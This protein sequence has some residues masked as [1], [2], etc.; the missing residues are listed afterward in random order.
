MSERLKHYKKYQ[1]QE[2]AGL[3]H[4]EFSEDS[5]A[6]WEDHENIHQK[7]S[8][9]DKAEIV[10]TEHEPLRMYLR[11]MGTIPLL[12]KENEIEIA[13]RIENSRKS[14]EKILFSFPYTINKVLSFKEKVIKD[15]T[16][17]SEIIMI[18]DDGNSSRIIKRRKKNLLQ[19]LDQ[20][21]KLYRKFKSSKLINC[22]EKSKA[23]LE[24][25]IEMISTLHLKESFISS[26]TDELKVIYLKIGEL[27]K[28]M[29]AISV[30]LRAKRHG[31]GTK[32]RL[33]S[34]SKK[35]ASKSGN[36][37]AAL[38]K[39]QTECRKEL[40]SY[41]SL[42][43]IRSSEM[44]EKMR[45]LAEAAEEISSAKK[46]M[47]ESNLRLVV[48]IAKR[49][50]GKGLDFD[51]LIQEGNIGL[52]RAIDK[53]EY[54]RGYKISTYATWWIRQ[55]I[56]R[57]LADQSRIIRMPV[58]MVD[59]QHQILRATREFLQEN[60]CEASPEDIAERIKIPTKKIK[61]ILKASKEPVSLETPI[62]DEEESHLDDFIEDKTSPSP[63]DNLIKQDLREQVENVLCRLNPK[64]SRIIR[65]RYGIDEDT[66][67]TL[68]ELGSDFNVSKER[69][70]QIE[71]KTI[72]K[73]R[74]SSICNELRLFAEKW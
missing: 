51:D 57:A 7:S 6:S 15:E 74:N 18:Q 54:Q 48:S 61:L 53:F 64:E 40:R 34:I 43:G 8:E 1:E 25:I 16:S 73:L 44:Q 23:T 20:I 66:T 62:G 38:L 45:G 10:N 5:E 72:Q 13:K 31:A 36:S 22:K 29:D 68:E 12:K 55:S 28:E 63:I 14:L 21:N 49:Y 30:Q 4:S 52:M 46:A 3:P 11:E 39:K 41:E 9:E 59:T 35:G 60:G 56:T 70:R 24:E 33:S 47:I 26:V 27:L 2:D 67:Q 42:A 58:H 37:Y 71:V 32:R 65:A 17:P 19:A 69:I 50:I